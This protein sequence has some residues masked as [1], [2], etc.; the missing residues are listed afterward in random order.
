ME[1]QKF[2]V[3]KENRKNTIQT[4]RQRDNNV[5]LIRA[6]TMLIVVFGHALDE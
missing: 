2:R 4:D 3:D 6:I 1:E 5:V